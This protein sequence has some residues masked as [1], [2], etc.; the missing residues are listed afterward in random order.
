MPPTVASPRAPRA[1]GGR[2]P[3]G[4]GRG[5]RGPTSRARSSR[6]T[7]RAPPVSLEDAW[8]RPGARGARPRSCGAHEPPA[9]TAMDLPV[10]PPVP[11]MLAKLSAA[12]SCA[13]TACST[14]PSGTAS[15]PSCSATVTRWRSAAATRSRSPATSPSWSPLRSAFARQGR[16][17]RR[18]R[19]RRCRGSR[20]RR[21]AAADP[22]GEQSRPD[23]RRR[24]A[25]QLRRLRPA[26]ARRRRPACRRRSASGG[27]ASRRR[28]PVW[29]HRFISP[30]D[31]R[32]KVAGEWFTR[33]E[34][35]GLDG[36]V[37]KPLDLPYRE[38]QRAMVK[39]KHERTADC[40]VAGFRWHKTGRSSARCCS[41]STTTTAS[42]ITSASSARSRCARRKELVDECV[43]RIPRRREF[44]E[45]PWAVGRVD[46][47][48]AGTAAPGGAVSRWNAN[49]DLSFEP[50]RPEL[51]VEV[52]YDHLQGALPPRRPLRALAPGP[53]RQSC[54]YDQLDDTGPRDAHHR[55]R[56]VENGS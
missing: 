44:A 10:M 47:G 11:P 4:P 17:R 42:S 51:V 38:D 41:A 2:D 5:C 28:W 15:A 29:R 18:D 21:A 20:L 37:V 13:G 12:R 46:A 3:R 49:K 35:A 7:G 53:R 23:A 33:F 32:R 22:P 27:P 48:G 30:R 43:V 25:R 9:C 19:R 55:L 34:G 52:F 50:L 45:H 14:S 16:A 8:H 54:T 1:S 56:R 39:V 31:R 24:D 26:G 40:V 36:V 6:P